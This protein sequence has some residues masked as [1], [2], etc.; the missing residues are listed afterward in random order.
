MGN[1]YSILGVPRDAS[2]KDIKSA[3]RRLARQYH[4]DVNQDDAGAEE[5]FKEVTAAYEIIGDP[6]KRRQFDRGE[7]NE[8]GERAAAARDENFGFGWGPFTRVSVRNRDVGVPLQVPAGQLFGTSKHTLKY[9]RYVSCS[10]CR[11]TG[12]DGTS[13]TCEAC[14]GSG[15]NTKTFRQAAAQVM[16]DMGACPRCFGKGVAFSDSC[17]TC[18]GVGVT[19]EQSTVEV[20][21][22]PGTANATL[23]LKGGGHAEDPSA[24]PGNLHVVIVPS[25]PACQFDHQDAIYELRVDPVQAILGCDIQAPGV[26]D[27]ETVVFPVAPGC[28]HGKVVDLPEKGLLG[29]N[30]KRGKARGVIVYK[31][32]EALNERQRAALRDYLK[33]G[34]SKEQTS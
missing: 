23:V 15:R 27:N 16:Y 21:V 14:H 34:Q 20:E 31:M 10:D 12:G 24:A 25:H 18:G 8:S 29:R 6:D 26:K 3:Y 7:I 11:G 13:S 32:P 19:V 2:E 1:P 30:G 4:P 17:H 9:D 28:S 33:A 22:P 5:K